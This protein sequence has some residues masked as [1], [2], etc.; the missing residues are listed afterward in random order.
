MADKGSFKL[1][2]W[3]FIIGLI[4]AIIIAIVSGP[5]VPQW[6][7]IVLAILGI[8]VG[9][10]NVTSAEVQKFLIAAIAF[11]LSF[12]SLGDV[13]TT[14]AGGWGGIGTFFNLLSV[15]MAPAAAVVA[16]KALFALAKD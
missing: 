6:A 1:G 11:L 12:K 5:V 7:V 13:L 2:V 16:I 8:I 15:F 10:L 3:A 4:L 14:L 9:L